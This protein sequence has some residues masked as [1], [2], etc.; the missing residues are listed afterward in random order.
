MN[1]NTDHR[2]NGDGWR[3]AV[4]FIAFAAIAAYFLLSEH[5]VH[6]LSILPWALILFA[7]PLL[8]MFM[9]GGHGGHGGHGDHS[10]QNGSRVDAGLKPDRH[11]VHSSAESSPHR[12]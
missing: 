1:R 11:G 4:V 2:S 3:R 9:H 10:D 8:H 6:A 7:C 12:H 5:R